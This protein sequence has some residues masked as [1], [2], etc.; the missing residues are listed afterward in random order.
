M[1][2]LVAAFAGLLACVTAGQAQSAPDLTATNLAL[3]NTANNYSLG[4]TGMRGWIYLQGNSGPTEIMTAASPW[5]ILVTTVGTGTPASGILASNDVILG[6][7]TGAGNVPVPLFTNDSRKSIGWAIGA[8][9][10]GDGV[11]N[12]KRW[13]AGVTNDVTI[14]LGLSNLAYSATAPY[15]CPKSAIILSNA[16]NILANRSFNLNTPGNQVLGLAMLASGNTNFLSSVQTYARSIS[17]IPVSYAMWDWSYNGIFLAEYFLKTGDTNVLPVLNTILVNIANGTDRYGTTCHTTSF[18]NS[19]GSYNGTSA[20]YG[21][22]NS[23][24]LACDLGLVLGQKALVAAGMTVNPAINAA[25][26]RGTNFFGWF[27]QKGEIPYG[28]HNPWSIAYPHYS[29]GKLGQAALMFAMVGDQTSTEYYTRMTLAAYIAREYGHTGQGF[30]YL[31]D[32]LGA[33][34]GGTNAMAAYIQNIEWHLD[35][36][37]RCDGSFVYDGGEQYG[38]SQVSDYWQVGGN[39]AYG[40]GSLDP[41]ACY[42][43]TYATPLQQIYLTGRNASPTNVL[44]SDKV[45]NALWAATIPLTV[46]NFTTNQLISA[47]GE[48]DPDVRF[49]AALQ[50][51]TYTN[52]SV[53]SMINLAGST[54]AWLR[55]SACTVLGAMKDTNGLVPL[56]QC[57]T[58][59]DVSVRGH[60]TLALSSFASAASPLV[61]TMLA[62]FITNATDPNV[63]NWNDPVQEVESLLSVELFGDSTSGANTPYVGGTNTE[64]AAKS[65]LYPAVQIGLKLPDSVPRSNAGNF[66]KNY[67]TL[68]DVQT[69]ALDL[70]QCATSPVLAD[71]M[72][73]YGGRT[74]SIQTL[75]KYYAAETVPVGMSMIDQ[76]WVALGQGDAGDDIG[77]NGALSAIATFGDSVRYLLPAFNNYASDWGSGDGRYVTLRSA[78]TSISS[79]VTSP[80]ITNLFPVAYSQVVN[81]TN[82][83]AITLTGSSCR[84]NVLSFLN[85]STPAHGT[86]SGGVPYLTY[87]PTPGYVGLD[88]FTFQVADSMTNSATATVSLIVGAPAGAGLNGQYYDNQDFTNLKFTRIDPQINFDWGTGTPSNTIASGTYSVRWT[89]MLLAPESGYY[90]FSTMNSDGVRLYVNGVQMIDDW[91]DQ[92][93]NWTDGSSLY[94]NAGQSYF[95]QMDFYKNTGSAVAKLKWTGPSFAGPNGV[96]ITKEWLYNSTAGITNLPVFAYPQGFTIPQNTSANIMLGGSVNATS[97]STVSG[98]SHGSLSGTPPTVNYTPATNYI[99]ADSFTF[100]ANNGVSNSSPATI[101]ISVLAGSPVAFN[102]TNTAAG[103]WSTAV[104]WTNSL[105]GSVAPNTAGQP[106]YYLQFNASTNTAT[107]DLNSGFALNQLNFAGIATLAGNSITL[108]TNGP[109]LPQINQNSANAVVINSPLNLAATTTFGGTGGGNVTINSLIS[110]AG[111]LVV[112]SPGNLNLM[113]ITNT[114]SGGTII[115]A[116]TVTGPLGVGP[117]TPFF[118]TGLITFNPAATYVFNRHYLTNSI[119]LNG[120]SLS[121]GNGFGST[122]AGPMT[123]MGI[124]T[125]NLGNTGGIGLNGNI[126]GTG[127]LTT[128][129]TTTWTMSGTNSYT[130]PTTIAAGGIKYNV[131][132]AV[133]PGALFIGSNAVA[134]LNYSGSRTNCWLNLNGVDQP[135]GVY[136]STN[137]T[138]TFKSTNFLGTGTLT[139]APVSGSISNLPAANV[140][141]TAAALN[142]LLNGN[143]APY[144]V[145]AYW[146]TNNAGTNAAAWGN[147]AVVGS[148]TLVTPINT[149]YSATGLSPGTSYYFTCR[150]FNALQSL[151][152]TNIQTFQTLPTLVQSTT[153]IYAPAPN[154]ASF[155]VPPTALGDYVIAMTATTANDVNGV[156]YL[157]TETTGHS[158]GASSGWQSSPNYTNSGLYPGTLYTYTV[159]Y[160]DLSTNYN[161][162]TASAS[163]SATT[164]IDTNPPSPNPMTFAIAPTALNYSSITMTATTA[165][166]VNGVE[167]YFTCTAGGGHDSGWQNGTNYTDTGLA[168]NTQYS[169]TV[170]ARDK[171]INQ[172]ATTPSSV[173]SATTPMKVLYWDGGTNNLAGNGDGMSGGGAGTWNPT[174]LNWDLNAGL[175]HVA[176]SNAANDLAVFGGMAGTVTVGAGISAGNLRFDTSNYVLTNGT[177]TLLG[178][179]VLTGSGNATMASPLAGTAGLTKL[180]ISTVT[181]NS[182]TT[183]SL[184]GGL[185]LNGGTLLVDFTNLI[186]STNLL[187]PNNAVAFGGGTLSFNGKSTTNLTQ[188]LG[189]VTVNAGGGQLLL[190]PN[191]AS[192]TAALNL[193]SI[194][195]TTAGGSLLLGKTSGASGTATVTTTSATNSTGTYGGRT[196]WFNG[197]A[198]TGYDWATSTNGSAP[199]SLSAY[200]GYTKLPTSGGSSTVNY[201]MTNATTLTGSFSVNSLKLEAATGSLSNGNNTLTLANGG[202]LLT[203]TSGVNIYGTNGVTGLTAGNGSGASDLV[204]HQCNSGGANIY[205]VIGDNGT[206]SVSLVKSGPGMLTLYATNTYTGST[207]INAGMIYSGTALNPGTFGTNANVTVQ[208]GA[209]LQCNRGNFTGTLTLNGGTWVDVNG[210]GGGWTGPVILN[211]DSQISSGFTVSINGPLSGAGALILGGKVVLN[212]NNTYTGN[213]VLN[214]SAGNLVLGAYGS[215]SNTPN[216][217][218]AAGTTFDVS[219][220]NTAVTLGAGQILK[221]SAT[222]TNAAA[223]LKIAASKGLTLGGGLA[224]TAYAGGSTNPLVVTGSGGAL[225][226]NGAPVI[227]TT[228]TTL[229]AGTYTLIGTNGAGA[230]VSGTPGA[231]TVNGSGLVGGGSATLSVTNGNL[232]L[233]VVVPTISVSGTLA[234]L[235]TTYGTASTATSFS[236]SGAYMAAGITV[237]PP[238][239]FELSTNSGTTG[240]AGSGNA[241]TVGIAGNIPGT[242]IYVR[243]AASATVAGSPYAGNIVCSSSLATNVNVATASSPVSP[244][245]LTMTGL[246]GTDKVYDGTAVAAVTGTPA[247]VGL[248][249]GESFAVTGTPSF[250]FADKNVGNNKAI[251]VSGYTAPTSNYTLSQPVGL[252]AS[253]TVL[254][255]TVAAVSNTKTYDGTTSSAG[256]PTISPALASGDTTSVLSQSFNTKHVGTGKTLTPAITINDG[257]SGNNYSVTL[258][259]NTTGVITVKAVTVTAVTDSKTYDGT[260]T[261]TG[262]PTIS[263]AL[264]SGDTTSALSQSFNTKHVGTGKTLTPAITIN[265]GNSGNNYSLT[266][267]NNT[268]GTI[269]ALAVTV[270]AVT[271]SKTYD[272]T[273]ASTGTPTISPALAGGDTTSALNQAFD[274]KH[275]GT[276]KTLTPS[277]TISDGNSGNNYSVTLAN[278]TTGVITA[279][280]VTVTAVTD[281]K[282][283]DGTTSSVGTPT[284]SP[285]LVSGDTTSALSQ[286][287]STKHIGTGK[288]LTPSVTINDGNSGNNYSVTLANNPT[289]VITV[290]AVAV[291]AVTDSKTYDGTSSSAGTPTISPALASGD[292]T[293]ALSQAFNNKNVGTGKTLTPAV[294]INDGNSGNNYSVTLANNTNGVITALGLTVTAVTDS[295][296]YDGTTTS[297]G[298]PT[299][300]PALASGDMTATLSQTFDTKHAGT[301]KTLTPTVTINDGNSGNNYS[302]TLANNTN[303]T[304]NALGVTVAAVADTKTYDGTTS[305]VGVPTISPALVSGDTTGA[306]SQTFATKHAGTSK[307]L[308]PAVTINDGNSGNNYSVT[309]QNATNGTINAAS[310]TITAQANTKIYDASTSAAAVPACS[311]VFSPDT[312]TGLAEA[313]LDPNTGSNKTLVATSYMVNDGNGGNNYAVTLVAN[314]NGIINFLPLGAPVAWDGGSVNITNNGDG[315]SAG[316]SGTW[317]AIIQNWDRDYGQPHAAWTNNDIAVFGGMA[318]TVT[319]GTGVSV[320]SLCFDTANYLLTNGTLTLTSGGVLTGSGNAIISPALAG[321]AGLIKVGINTVTLNGST[322]NSLTGGLT[323]NGGT[324]VVDFA[325]LGSPTNLLNPNNAVA[326]GGGI[327]NFKGSSTTNLNQTLGN[328]IVNAGG[329]QLL[330]NPNGASRTA[331][332]NLGSLT[333]TAAGSSLLLGKTSGASGTA[334]VTTTTAPDATG[335]Y[336]GRTVWFNGTAGTGYDWATS[337]N[338]SAPYSLSAYTGYTILPTSGGSSTVNYKMTSATTLT[339]NMTI[340]SLKLEASTGNLS[341]GS[342]T[343]TLANGGLLLTGTSGVNIYG[344]NGVTGLTAGNGS[345]AYD[346]V[347]HQCNSGGANIYAVIGDNGTN[348]VSLVKSGSGTLTLL[349]SNTC[350]GGTFVNAG[351]LYLRADVFSPS[352]VFPFSA[353]VQ[354]GAVLEG[355]KANMSGTLTL[356][357]GT[358]YDNNG[359]GG[360]WTG[361]VILNADSF[362]GSSAF[363]YSFAQTIN[364]PLNGLGGV[365][366]ATI[367][368]VITLNGTNTYT[369]NTVLAQGTLILGANGSISNTP[370]ITLAAGTTFDVSVVNT[371]VALGAGQILKVS[372]TGTN[373]AATLKIAASKGLTLGGGLALTA[374]AGG[375][376]NPLVVTGSGGAL[377]LNGAPV[378]VT[379]TTTL[380]AGTYT[381]IGTN[382][383]GATVSGTPGALT[384]NGSGLVGGGSATLSVTNGNL[385]LTVVVPTIS[386]SG[387][388]AALNTTYG[389]ASTATSFSVSGAYMAAGITVTPPSGFE[390]STNSGTAGFAGSGNPITV[391]SVGN[392]P[393]TTVYARLATNASVAG[394]PYS[395]NIVCSSSWATNVNVATA[396][397]TLAPAPLTI[398]GLTG[399]DKVYDGTVAAGT[400]GTPAY[401]GLQNGEVFSVSGTP[402]FTF[403]DKNVGAGKSITVSGYTAPSGNYTVSQPSGLTANITTKAV[404]VTAVTASKTYDGTIAS[405]GTPT[406]SPVLASGDTTTALSQSFNTKNVGTGKTLTPTITINDGNSGNNYSVTLANNTTGIITA[407]AVT[408][409]AVTDSKTYDGTITSAATP[410]ISPAL[411]S[412]DTTSVLSQSFNTKHV[413]T[414][415]TLTPTIT[416]NDGNSGNNYSV[417][418]ANNT[419]GTITALALTVT[420]VADSKT[421]DGTITS[422]ATPTISPAL[423]SGDTTNSLSQTFDTK[424]VGTGKTL[425][426]AVTINDGNSGNNYS[427]TL[428]NNTIG[429]ITAKAVTV[430]AVTD[431]KTYDGTTSSAGTPT[432][433]PALAGGDTTNALSQSFNTKNVGTGKTLTPAITIN[434]GNSGN[435]YSVTL[436]NNTNGVITAVGLTIT[437]VANTKTFDGTNSAAA[438]PTYGTVFSPDTVTGLVEAYLDANIGSNKTLVVTGYVVNDGNSGNNY[439][440]TLAT[441]FSGVINPPAQVW[442]DGGTVNITTNGNGASAGGSGT[443]NTTIQ[444]WDFG[445]GLAHYGWPNNSSAVFGGA[446][447]TVTLGAAVS[448]SG[449]QFD[450]ANYVI[451]SNTVTLTGSGTIAVNANATINSVIA[452]ASGLTKTG[453][454]TLTLGGTNTFSG[455][456]VISSNT[457]SIGNIANGGSPSALGQ[458]SASATNLVLGNG[459]TL[460]YTGSGATSDRLFTMSGSV[461]LNGSGTGALVLTNAGAIGFGAAN[462]AGTLNLGGAQNLAITNILTAQIT[463]NGTGQ[464]QIAHSVA[465]NLWWLQN[466]NNNFSGGVLFSRGNLMFSS[467][468]FGTNGLIGLGFNCVAPL[469]LA[470]APGNSDDISKQFNLGNVANANSVYTLV[471]DVGTNNVNFANGINPG[472]ATTG[473]VKDGPGSL[474]M[475]G[476]NQWAGNTCFTAINAGTLAVKWL[477]NGGIN[478]GLGGA[479]AGAQYFGLHG[480]STFKYIGPGSTNDHLFNITGT[481]TLDASGTGP[482]VFTNLGLISPAVP[483]RSFTISSNNTASGNAPSSYG[484]LVVGQAVGGFG[485]KNGTVITSIGNNGQ[486]NI[487]QAT[488]NAVTNLLF[489]AYNIGPFTLAGTNTGNNEIKGRFTDSVSGINGSSVPLSLIKA[490]TGTWILSGT[491]T[492]SGNT[493]I[494]GGTLALSG[495][496]LITNSA[497]IVM[498][499]NAIFNVSRLSNAF[500]LAQA[501]SSQT[502][503]NSA[504]GAIINGT[505]NC[506]AGTLSLVYDGVNPCFTLTNGGMTL[507]YSTTIKINNTGATLAAGSYTLITNITAGNAGFVAGTVTSAVTVGGNGTSGTATL[508]VTGNQLVLTVA[509]GGM[510]Q[511]KKKVALTATPQV[512]GQ[513]STQTA[514][515]KFT[516]TYTGVIG[517]TYVVQ[518][519]TDLM[520]WVNLETNILSTAT[521]TYA[522]PAP[523]SSPVFY[524]VVP[525]P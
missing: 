251:S 298:T 301:G 451:N 41:T 86:L 19:D 116:G 14:H 45:T 241:I 342:N 329:G 401:V 296:T 277:V 163:A 310:L 394:S 266:L 383:A 420:A 72:W 284:I 57:L 312:V 509:S 289:G 52:I 246:T 111:S 17:S 261:S 123:L 352:I 366:F 61:P 140:G 325:K 94:L 104:N 177:L 162:G 130:G 40:Y 452:G 319:V 466:P 18:L 97:F 476:T 227:V 42:V 453:S 498:A 136:G 511:I 260:T 458:S 349:A 25:I 174:N 13:R 519:S 406:I 33:N 419:N 501:L 422:V 432:I 388:L 235:N 112:N 280:A 77:A 428:A 73:R 392:I 68:A 151:W 395:G 175:A 109:V 497:N 217:I 505:N 76:P 129:G 155:A 254:P 507:S 229:G 307:T 1:R 145:V 313:Y 416:I 176:W 514:G 202:L 55:A 189:N 180:N 378:I 331:A 460:N 119:T 494:S 327:L 283:Y 250:V 345:G 316:G 201:K 168:G 197:T 358:W 93:R 381:L 247:Y 341:N 184:T 350:S 230:T 236:V 475:N 143:G 464:V 305:S 226:L 421:Y 126:S 179:G 473:L 183:N 287:F 423:V 373:A 490:G 131:A 3:I 389:T 195:A 343:L 89:G 81:T 445:S 427:V 219:G 2:P 478:D 442:W 425:T 339:G 362:I 354:S 122:L 214:Q 31:W 60:A 499:S 377:A 330:L 326:F 272:G 121:G 5:Q 364:G 95:V 424:N 113:N 314:F 220:V 110:G 59:P 398:T 133:A 523:P 430:T 353:T 242:T 80:A 402:G 78:I 258:A 83:V 29:N 164:T 491:N 216:I 500:T 286:V 455:A 249:N 405:A 484:D 321:T 365:T 472:R 320:G 431:S 159:T 449:L 347:I 46:T 90:T 137:S 386:V 147:S 203:G 50:L 295:K 181:L 27:V 43:L 171:S 16:I 178:G 372:A 12:L 503:S 23:T 357:G 439:N 412:G 440:V 306:L 71:P 446:A 336:G 238:A 106:Y 477:L 264:A 368:S 462:Q 56:G 456:V 44:S 448:A 524:R 167:Y 351:T 35:L 79:A 508:S 461:T 409:T 243:L 410:T 99:G 107:N 187:N 375:S 259:N 158:G 397:S 225:A 62:A 186:S 150:A 152:D 338:G 493:T 273:I 38:P 407:K 457:L 211:A 166:D 102:W 100:T 391:G 513:F 208:S 308:T 393:V 318:G 454:G 332:L 467:G 20:G 363:G 156:Q 128:V 504:P 285:A 385:L 346:L 37:R 265:D 15:N 309:L 245:A 32:A 228:T 270:T 323:L 438:V 418:L 293:S 65:L 139:V 10:A 486:L 370:S 141:A 348:S 237:T 169:Y 69:L 148:W 379:T 382:G 496:G 434:D 300:S 114:Y 292:S 138:A 344:T 240:F 396:S 154:P 199:Y 489:G 120:T 304:I 234:A 274:T 192:R 224:L 205:T 206:N 474:T 510:G 233:T 198:G 404:T 269:S 328:V 488:T 36:E 520:K 9:E 239:G 335:I 63:V 200:T 218:M 483:S 82:A 384:V 359:F 88:S 315:V 34:L 51:G 361:P 210:F 369:G 231:L 135:A 471:L 380:G 444:N 492:Y 47:L 53:A 299:I 506:S 124:S 84:T 149:S 21:P 303:G 87:T 39:N 161:V 132:A 223:T 469:V 436:A 105:G 482:L 367:G 495:A 108:T 115:N 8:A 48:F 221:V 356:N 28:E 297:A 403:A 232:L 262:T 512:K 333:A 322:T 146:G 92:S 165:T 172:N 118:G 134:N 302:L 213:T 263:P 11:M 173:F 413:G 480:V 26:M 204:I 4:P 194:T 278:N 157:F 58:D 248:Q 282:T 502:L 142:A 66:L 450:T 74:A 127:G 22:V 190:N 468:A 463:D 268:N 433:S 103:L 435:N 360:S 70:I 276:G 101:T 415:K 290:K 67:A 317:D 170:K 417:T 209:T 355:E 91:A 387:T 75:A 288:T 267:A 441:N 191:G 525:V 253:I 207:Y 256:V 54:N 374:Y 117:M 324:L 414:G 144:T 98:P 257:N 244:A 294:T 24:G 371:A 426:P 408:V 185:T 429:V 49:F 281:T 275:V 125:I 64:A 196:V 96:L 516:V 7:S 6:V 470:W 188:T 522:D 160:R 459:A 252:T 517:Q 411:A 340:N 182:S 311:A 479:P 30:N 85:V 255:V 337:T 487:S 376:T 271:D 485:V 212:T 481:N 193:G 521:A 334:A 399:V 390:L 400:T 215:I 222:G 518:R 443:W 515:S 465:N 291:T 279:K 153:D 447:G 437:A